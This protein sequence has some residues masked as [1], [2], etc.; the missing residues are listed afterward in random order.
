MMEWKAAERLREI[1][2]HRCHRGEGLH[3][4][5]GQPYVHGS[6][7]RGCAVLAIIEA[8]QIER[9]RITA[10]LRTETSR[11]VE[12]LVTMYGDGAPLKVGEALVEAIGRVQ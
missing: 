9:E 12:R 11:I 3:G 1:M 6:C 10:I 7:C 5:S 8:E 2:F 4:A